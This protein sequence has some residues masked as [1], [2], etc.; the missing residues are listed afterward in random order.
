MRLL[1]GL[2]HNGLL[3]FI[4]QDKTLS[5]AFMQIEPVVFESYSNLKQPSWKK[6]AA[7]WDF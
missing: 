2:E 1:K 7:A 6:G 4:Y 3:L 5:K